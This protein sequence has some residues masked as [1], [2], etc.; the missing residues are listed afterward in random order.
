MGILLKTISSTPCN[1]LQ[2]HFL[3]ILVSQFNQNGRILKS[4]MYKREISHINSQQVEARARY[5]LIDVQK[6]RNILLLTEIVQLM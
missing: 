3:V 4:L 5:S 6:L 1:P 2:N